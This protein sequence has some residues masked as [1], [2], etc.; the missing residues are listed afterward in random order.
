MKRIP[1]HPR[2]MTLFIFLSLTLLACGQEQTLPAG[3]DSLPE[4]IAPASDSTAGGRRVCRFID[5][6]G[7][8]FNDRA[9]DHDGDGIPN[10]LDPDWRRSKAHRV[11]R[12]RQLPQLHIRN[13]RRNAPRCCRCAGPLPLAGG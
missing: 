12:G 6:D 1:H 11:R 13:D 2:L 4:T 8:G 7:D 5:R 10:G 9:R 3:E